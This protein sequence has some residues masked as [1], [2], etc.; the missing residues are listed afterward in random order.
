MRGMRF[1][2]ALVL[3]A[4]VSM[5]SGCAVRTG[6]PA[7]PYADPVSAAEWSRVPASPELLEL[8]GRAEAGD[9]LRAVRVMGRIQHPSYAAALAKA[10]RS[11]ASLEVRDA[12]LFAL[13]QYGLVQRGELPR[14]AV[15]ACEAGSTHARLAATAIECLGKLADPRGARALVATAASGDAS[16]R[17]AVADAAM[18]FRFAPVWRGDVTEPPAWPDDLARTLESLLTDG[19]PAVRRAAAHACSRYAAPAIAAALARATGDTDPDVRWLAVRALG[20]SG[21]A[22]PIDAVLAAAGD[23]AAAVRVEAAEA[24]GVLGSGERL[25]AAL[26]TDPS[27]HARAAYA[28]ALGRLPGSSTT[29]TELLRDE[30]PTV[31]SAAIE[32]LATPEAIADGLGRKL[33]PVRAAAGRATAGLGADHFE[34]VERGL[35]D[36]DPRV[37]AATLGACG[38]RLSHPEVRAAA[39]AALSSAD[40]GELGTAVELIAAS[41]LP[42]RVAILERAYR[43]ATGADGTEIAE[44]IAKELRNEGADRELLLDIAQDPRPTVR[45]AAKRALGEPVA[46]GPVVYTPRHAPRFYRSVP[47][48]TFVTDRGTFEVELFHEDAPLHVAN[49]AALANDGF[50]DG[51]P[52]HRVV[53]NFVVQGGDPQGSGWGGPGYTVPDEI[54]RRRFERGTLGMPKTVK[55]TGGCQVFFTHVATPHLDGNYTAFGRV[56]SGIEVIDRIEIGDRIVSVR[57]RS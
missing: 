37:R 51:L 6:R 13:G 42:E 1:A 38:D 3:T 27:F 53:Q 15:D 48:A 29:L 35:S 9:R 31:V 4:A 50:Y 36:P 20:R 7:A 24:A 52:W 47:H 56:V 40:L 49:F 39:E 44:T 8:L 16:V 19:D 17:A 10:A 55:D 28:R 23:P 30:S 22:A 41:E 25:P 14:E 34:L 54:S 33:W 18:R 57:V 11:D 46:E 26:A 5:S 45:H 12:A 32:A 43:E 21:E 2:V